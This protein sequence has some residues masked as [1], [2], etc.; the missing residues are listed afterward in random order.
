MNKYL[1]YSVIYNNCPVLLH[2]CLEIQYHLYEKGAE[3]W[4]TRLSK[5]SE[6]IH[7]DQDLNYDLNKAIALLYDQATNKMLTV[8]NDNDKYPKLR[9]YKTFKLDVRLESYLNFNFPKSI[10][11]SIARF[12]LSSH[13]LHIE[14]GRHKRPY[15]EAKDRICEKCNSGLI[16]DEMHC[17]IICSKWNDLRLNLVEEASS[18]IN[19]FFVLSQKEQFHQIMISKNNKLNFAL[20]KFLN[21]ALKIDA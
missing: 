18:C 7:I 16:E 4:L 9:T 20:G 6:G 14:L 1:F 15:V 12:R 10:Y 19:D 2:K 5:I 3:C 13:N 17:L 11:T 8:I 21:A